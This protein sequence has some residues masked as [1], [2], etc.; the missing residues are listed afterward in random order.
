[1][2]R[3]YVKFYESKTRLKRMRYRGKKELVLDGL[4][5]S[6]NRSMNRK[7]LIRPRDTE[8]KEFVLTS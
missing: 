3:L 7:G 5:T 4:N 6:L 1:M 2:E 8:R